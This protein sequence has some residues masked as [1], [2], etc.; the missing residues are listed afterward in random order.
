MLDDSW[1][2][3]RRKQKSKWGLVE[4]SSTVTFHFSCFHCSSGDQN[5]RFLEC[6]DSGSLHNSWSVGFEIDMKKIMELFLIRIIFC[7]VWWTEIMDGLSLD[8]NCNARLR[9][10]LKCC[11]SSSAW[12]EFGFWSP[13]A[14]LN[15]PLSP[16][17][18]DIAWGKGKKE[19]ENREKKKKDKQVNMKNTSG[20]KKAI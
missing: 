14:S 3:E 12:L 5:W 7:W 1:N 13:E 19:K 20:T 2:K 17:G 6:M 18:K 10:D 11:C 15:Y 4:M 16:R 8:Q 9:N